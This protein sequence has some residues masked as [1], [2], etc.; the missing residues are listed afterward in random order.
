MLLIHGWLRLKTVTLTIASGLRRVNANAPTYPASRRFQKILNRFATDFPQVIGEDLYR[1]LGKFFS[2]KIQTV[3]AGVATCTS[4][5]PGGKSSY[6]YWSLRGVAVMRNRKRLAEIWIALLWFGVAAGA[7]TVANAARVQANSNRDRGGV[8]ADGILTI[9]LEVRECEWFPEDEHGQSVKVFALAENGKQGQIPGPMIR[10]RQGTTIHLRLRNLI[11]VEVVIHGMHSRPGKEDDVLDIA[12]G[13]KSEATFI[14]GE[15]GAYYYWASAGGDTLSG[16]PYKEDSQLNGAFIVDPPGEVP[17]DRV[18]V[19]AAW[20]DRP[21]PQ[22]SFDISVINGKSWPYT[23]RLE[24]TVGSDVRWR[25]LNP[26]AQLHPMH[27]HG[28]YFRVD[29]IGDAERETVLATSQRKQV[30]TQLIPVGGTMTMYWQPREAGRWLFH[31]HILTHVS[32]ET[33]FLRR[34]AKA[35]HTS[36]SHNHAEQ[37]MAGL[38]MGIT[39]LPRPG[40]HPERKVSKPRRTLNLVIENQNTGMNARGY[41]LSESG[42]VT[43]RVSAPG[44]AI[45]LTRGEP[46]AIHVTNRLSEPTSVHWHGIELQ[47]YYD[48]VPGWTGYNE[49]VTPMIEAGKSFDVYFTPPRAGTFIY[50]THMDDMAQLSSG[51]YGPIV[52]LAPGENYDPETDKIFIMGRNGKRSDG[53]FLV[54]GV[55]KPQPQ[56]WRVGTGYRLRFINMNANNTVKIALTQNGA[57]V[58]WTAFA[59]DG[60]DLPAEQA[61]SGPASFLIAPGETYDYLFRPEQE[62]DMQLTF[63]LTLLKERVLQV[64]RLKR[65]RNAKTDGTLN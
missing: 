39:V 65:V 40:E 46:V 56:K 35:S 14:A 57:P 25:W 11:S 6:R 58:L 42:R 3:P 28:S 41:S 2:S 16:R 15:P 59:K 51:L 61:L 36:M 50:H 49:Q 53:E 37:D 7:E 23:E 45:V 10:V 62:G 29:A 54:N 9:N 64:I 30:A 5:Q 27:M 60:A 63:D 4:R 1:S 38:V 21:L 32:P 17:P 43:D 52:V 22:E 19:I 13:G 44:P 47:S 31:C 24:Y 8:L 18:F 48:G 12:P 34:D 33:M 26:S 20:R 55:A